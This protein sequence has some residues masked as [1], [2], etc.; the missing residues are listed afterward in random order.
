VSD[1]PLGATG[2]RR[3]RDEGEDLGWGRL[4]R[5]AVA[6]WRCSLAAAGLAL[7]LGLSACESTQEKSARLERQA[8]H[9]A[10]GQRGLQIAKASTVVKVLSATVVRDSEGAAVAV[11]VRNDSGRALRE[12]PLAVTVRGTSG[13]VLYENNAAGL[14]S[15]LVSIPSLAAHGTL[16]WVDDQVPA[17]G[18]PTTATAE[19]G[20]AR[21]PAGPPPAIA[22]SGLHPVEDPNNGAGA[23]GTV[24]NRSG[25]AQT[26]LPVFVIALRGGRVVAAARAVLPSLGPHSSLRFQAFLVGSPHGGTLQASA[27]PSS[28]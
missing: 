28:F 27:P 22:I 18:E 1:A 4:R 14:E 15:A 17:N 9:V 24:S 19:V 16:T 7:G 10:L 2:G 23:G 20:E 8:K 26:N 11:T 6:A 13:Q 21:K 3:A 12:L 5:P 25:V